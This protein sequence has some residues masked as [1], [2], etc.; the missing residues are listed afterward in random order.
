MQRFLH[1]GN[2]VQVDLPTKPV[3]P[4]TPI[5]RLFE[6][7]YPD[8]ALHLIPIVDNG[9]PLGL[10]NRHA[11]IERFSKPYQRELHGKEPCQKIIPGAPLLVEKNMP[12][13]ELSHFLAE[14]GS[15]HLTE[16]FII[17]EN[18]RY[19]GVAT[20]RDLL[21]ELTQ[22]QI[23][24]ARYA[25][26][27]TLLPGNVPINDHIEHLLQMNIPFVACYTDL[28]FFKPFNDVYGYGK[29][30]E[31]IRLTGRILNWACDPKLDFIGHIGGDD[32]VLLLQ[33]PNWQARCEQA[34]RSFE[35]ATELMFTEEHRSAGGYTTE[36]RD[37]KQ[38][39]HPLTSLS[40]GALKVAPGEFTSYLEVAAAMTDTKKMA[41]KISG[42]SLF[43]EQRH[44]EH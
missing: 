43:V 32:F 10:I 20:G 11:F 27:L 41:N 33:S 21:R 24:A 3:R 14:V 35:Q 31:M 12:L 40:I 2:G 37:G 30:D 38:Q 1:P 26:P 28:D 29:G 15:R 44:A 13:A 22:M 23:E 5:D 39:F 9:V 17:T 42:N 6:C 19:T 16:G 8:P 4:E 7:F 36:G 25:N 34:L 18:G